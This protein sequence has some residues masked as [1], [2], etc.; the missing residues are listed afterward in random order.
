MKEYAFIIV[1]IAAMITLVAVAASATVYLRAKY[2]SGSL[3]FQL[4]R[5]GIIWVTLILLLLASGFYVLT[6]TSWT[7]ETISKA[8]E[9]TLA[10]SQSNRLMS[11]ILLWSGSI[12]ILMLLHYLGV[13]TLSL[14]IIIST[15]HVW[16]SYLTWG[17]PVWPLIKSIII[18]MVIFCCAGEYEFQKL[19]RKQSVTPDGEDAQD[20][21]RR[22]APEVLGD[23]I[24]ECADT[25]AR[26]GAT[27][28]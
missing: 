12:L 23:M 10:W 6:V 24:A 5:I 3:T 11:S 28:S 2:G 13:M 20:T 21:D 27:R 8:F 19:T 7:T 4:S 1:M 22:T 17:N 18:A 16:A 25:L 14:T 9:F 15:L 26:G